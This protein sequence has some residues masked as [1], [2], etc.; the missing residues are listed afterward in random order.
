[1]NADTASGCPPTR[2][3][4]TPMMAG[5]LQFV[6]PTIYYLVGQFAMALVILVI[7][8]HSFYHSQRGMPAYM[9][10]KMTCSFIW[11]AI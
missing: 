9:P 11:M 7:H 4:A 8:S 6:T 10:G 3:A 2:A 1:M 5:T